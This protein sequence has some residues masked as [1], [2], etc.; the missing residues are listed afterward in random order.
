M[1]ATKSERPFSILGVQQVAVGGSNLT[2]LR[3]LWVDLLGMNVEAEH[4]LPT[5]NVR[6]ISLRGDD[7]TS[8]QVH[9]MEPIDATR[10]P[11]ID[12]PPLHHVGL[13]VSDIDAAFAWLTQQG[14]RFAP[15]GIRIGGEG[16]RVCFIHPRPSE[17]H[18]QSGEGVLIELI[19]APDC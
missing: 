9:L 8:A 14:V 10:K 16:H 1:M 15:G 11:R 2:A 3:A 6:E 4:T 17:E 18:P 19:Q 5:E 7:N 13:W 12:H